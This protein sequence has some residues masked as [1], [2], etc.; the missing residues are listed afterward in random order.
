M[1]NKKYKILVLS[2]L[3][4]AT[5][6]TIKS[7]VSL[8]KMINADIQF[9]YV[10][11]P[12]DIIEKE[13]QLSAIR[14]INHEYTA[15]KKKIQDIVNPF[16]ETYGVPINY[17]F[18]FGN[19]KNEISTYIEE[20]QPDI[21]VLG[22]RKSKT[23]KFIGDNITDFVLKKHDGVIMIV[24]NS[25]TLEPNKELSLGILNGIEQNL[26]I[27]FADDLMKHIKEPLKSFKIVNNTTSI[28]EGNTDIKRQTIEY[29][30]EKGDN[31]IEYLSN[32]LSKKNINL[33]CVDR[34]KKNTEKIENISEF[35]I[36]D[37]ISKLN[38][39]LLLTGSASYSKLEN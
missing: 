12:T 19:V 38:V 9:F 17:R 39:S 36:K 1:E 31:S 20:Y 33:L 32:Y 29:V 22:K 25:N 23:L 11:K 6:N 13:N 18:A 5:N 15:T 26:N 21:I 7:T 16:F 24:A 3:K 8:S 27:A 37:V 30:F 2:D 35:E 34:V 14:T 28:K 10:K 4:D